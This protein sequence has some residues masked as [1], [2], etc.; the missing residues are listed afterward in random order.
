MVWILCWPAPKLTV[1]TPWRTSQLASSPPSLREAGLLRGG[2]G[3]LDDRTARLE[4]EGEVILSCPELQARLAALVIGHLLLGL[5]ERVP[6][7]TGDDLDETRVVTPALALDV[8]VVG[9]D[10]RRL[11]GAEAIDAAEAADV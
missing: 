8:D 5:V 7:S 10:V 2:N 6:V 1:G 3:V 9:D 11:A 4:A